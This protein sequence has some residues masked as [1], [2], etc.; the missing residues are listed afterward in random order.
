[1]PAQ[2]LNETPSDQLIPQLFPVQRIRL[3]V[4][5]QNLG[6]VAVRLIQPWRAILAFVFR[7]LWIRVECC[8]DL[9]K[10]RGLPDKGFWPNTTQRSWLVTALS[11]RVN[12]ESAQVSQNW[13]VPDCRPYASHRNL[14][15]PFTRSRKTLLFFRVLLKPQQD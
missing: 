6:R 4:L 9:L 10:P 8:I 11:V 14:L 12:R 7:A 5:S 13:A 3:A 1:M 15:R 2:T